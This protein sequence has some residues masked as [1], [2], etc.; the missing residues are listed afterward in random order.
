MGTYRTYENIKAVILDMDGTLLDTVLDMLEAVNH[1][2]DMAGHPRITYEEFQPLIGG[3]VRDIYKA[4]LADRTPEMRE[5]AVQTH[6]TW[7]RAHCADKTCFYPGMKEML[8]ELSRR[9][10]KLAII[11]N[12]VERNAL[13]IA[14][15]FCSDIP[16]AEVWGNNDVRPLK[17]DP[18]VGYM[19]C[20]AL[21]VK[22]EEVLYVGDGDTDMR[23]AKAMGFGAVAA[24]WGYTDREI[25]QKNGAEVL[26]EK[27]LDLLELLA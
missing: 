22:P 8:M 12:K 15:H 5:Q 14:D 9:G 23:F 16:F 27:P 4:L 6:L 24:C 17:P 1:A 19:A 20:E 21:R 18:Q 7:Y 2:M 25:L 13:K 10:L 3:G 26:L 11:T